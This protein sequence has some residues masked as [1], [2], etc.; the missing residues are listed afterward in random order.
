MKDII[1]SKTIAAQFL[2]FF[3]AVFAILYYPFQLFFAGKWEAKPY[4]NFTSVHQLLSYFGGNT[5]A[6]EEFL[7]QNDI[8]SIGFRYYSLTLFIGVLMGFYLM[9][10]FFKKNKIAESTTERL[11]IAL[12]LLGLIG[13][14]LGFVA[15]NWNYYSENRYQEII[16]FKAGGLTLYGGIATAGLYLLYY[17][18]SKKIDFRSTLDALIPA[19][20]MVM[21]WAR[22]GN[23]FNYE[24]YGPAT[25]LP[26]KMYVPEGAATNNRYNLGGKLER[27][28]HPTFL[29][30][31]ILNVILFL[32][33]TYIYDFV[34]VK[35]KGIIAGFMM[36]GYGVGRFF[37]EEYRLDSTPLNPNLTYGQLFSVILA[38]IGTILI[39]VSKRELKRLD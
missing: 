34:T 19:T 21:I 12:V 2:I 11:F 17:C 1:S 8:T 27:F 30:E 39:I 24:A 28:Y 32:I 33:L 37:L 25:T 20:L 38:T 18:R 13:A 6:I 29:Y 23:F 35:R 14:R 10:Q 16:N 26:W 15:M 9:L 5:N 7:Q 22:L 31:I 4:V 3:M 36:I